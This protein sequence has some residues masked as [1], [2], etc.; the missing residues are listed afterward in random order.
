MGHS[1]WEVLFANSLCGETDKAG[2]TDLFIQQIFRIV[3]LL[4]TEMQQQTGQNPCSLDNRLTV[5]KSIPQ[6][7]LGPGLESVTS[8]SIHS[9]CQG[10]KC[11]KLYTIYLFFDEEADCQVFWLMFFNLCSTNLECERIFLGLKFFI[12]MFCQ[13]AGML[14]E[15]RSLGSIQLW[16]R[17]IFFLWECQHL[18]TPFGVADTSAHSAF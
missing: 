16:C 5:A 14:K 13:L 17:L 15:K 2:F 11:S 18:T 7:S 3:T 9:F 1:S 8:D 12:G 4:G 6:D 10:K